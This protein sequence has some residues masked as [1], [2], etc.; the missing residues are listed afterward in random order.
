MKRNSYRKKEKFRAR[1]REL[2]KIRQKKTTKLEKKTIFTQKLTQL[3]S[4]KPKPECNRKKEV[5]ESIWSN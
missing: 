4:Q 1:T 2:M 5:V 3:R